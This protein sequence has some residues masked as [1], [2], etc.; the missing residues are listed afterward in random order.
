L[1][2]PLRRDE[3][4][5]SLAALRQINRPTSPNGFYTP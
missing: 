1:P 5:N 4:N 2:T 3:G